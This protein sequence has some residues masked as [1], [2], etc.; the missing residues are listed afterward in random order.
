[1]LSFCRLAIVF[2]LW[3]VSLDLDE[4]ESLALN[5]VELTSLLVLPADS[6]F[7]PAHTREESALLYVMATQQILRHTDLN[8]SLTQTRRN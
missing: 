7:L 6:I 2:G 4:D 1:M 8:F 3:L 5:P